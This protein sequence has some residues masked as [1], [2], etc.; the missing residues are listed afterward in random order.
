[1]RRAIVVVLH[2]ALVAALLPRPE[3]DI[4]D[5]MKGLIAR[6]LG[7]TYVDQFVLEALPVDASSGLDIAHVDATP[8]RVHLRASSAT[9]MGYGLHA[10][11][12]AAAQTQTNWEDDPLVLPPT[13][14]A[15]TTPLRLGRQAA[16]TYYE[17]VCTFSYSQWSWSWAKWER[18][19]DWMVLNGINVPL[20]F[21]GQEKVWAT[22]FRA[23]NVSASGL[24]AFFAGASFLAWGRMGNIQ[25]SWVRGPLPSSFIEQQFELQTKILARMRAFGMTPAL[26]AFGGHVPAEMV[27]LYPNAKF[28]QSPPWVGFS[29]PFTS[30]MMLDPTDPLFLEI[31]S[32]FVRH[33]AA[34]LNY[35]A[36]LY[37]TDTYNEMD[38]TSSA[39]AYLAA[40]SSAVLRS[41]RA[42]HP[43]AV[44]LMQG[45]LFRFRDGLIVLDLYSEVKPMW[46]ATDNY[47]G[48]Y[49]IYCVLHNFGGSLGMRGDLPTVASDLVAARAMS[50]GTLLGLGLTMEGIFQNYI[51]Y[52]LALQMPWQTAAIDVPTYVDGFIRARYHAPTND[53]LDAW[54]RL[55]ATVYSVSK[56]FGGVTKCIVSLRPRWGLLQTRFM[57][58][59]LT[60]DADDVLFAWR[61]LLAAA[62]AMASH[63][64]F[65][66]D[67]VDVTRQVLSDGLAADLAALEAL[68]HAQVAPIEELNAVMRRM[69]DSMEML[70][71]ILNTN[72]HFMLGP[73][74]A[75]A[76]ALSDADDEM[77]N[78]FEYEAKNQ[79]TRWG[80]ANGNALSDYAGKDWGGLISTYY[81]PRWRI[82]W[83]HVR[84]AYVARS[85]VDSA[86]VHA[87]LEAFEL[88]WQL[89][90][91]DLPIDPVEDTVRVAMAIAKTL[92]LDE[93][94][95]AELAIDASSSLRDH[96][97]A[98]ACLLDC[99]W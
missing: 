7:Q 63:L 48:K 44:W 95:G 82:W 85:A 34:L 92:L 1:M 74:L 4:V 20:A 69:Q 79:V 88:A 40:S 24:D 80:D 6:R 99:L 21:T 30:V 19:I 22:T 13:L 46:Q 11:L 72:R 37:Q 93:N 65:T 25:G 96:V 73:W 55:A 70:E 28:V 14:P 66:R 81:L 23:F 84:H 39:P 10:Y 27:S 35:S 36:V 52:D 38:P 83:R 9:A 77:A 60:H 32:A 94:V 57:P 42:V 17:N 43:S 98:R 86:A 29:P 58:T 89:E 78:Y 54:Q 64:S 33:Q 71:R 41:M 49:W 3:H 97:L 53:A 91:S 2:A 90:R 26:P 56:G 15:L 18:H 16:Y 62:P 8:G 68:F 45:W 5:A 76:R 61:R 50:A 75:D 51:V 12:K 59:A 47:F 87:A 31:G 67:L